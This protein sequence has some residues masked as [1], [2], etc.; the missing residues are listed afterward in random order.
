M[1]QWPPLLLTHCCLKLFVIERF[2]SQKSLSLSPSISHTFK[3]PQCSV[4]GVVWCLAR[5][6]Q[7]TWCLNTYDGKEMS[8]KKK[9]LRGKEIKGRGIKEEE[10]KGTTS[11]WGF[12]LENL[13]KRGSF[14]RGQ[15]KTKRHNAR[16]LMT[17]ICFSD[18]YFCSP[19]K[20][21]VVL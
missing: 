14:F 17:A 10:E 9:R 2:R 7:D 8:K 16:R 18:P 13:L 21:T 11:L 12:I 1:V 6:Q 15:T 19:C 20:H 4:C 3:I 5:S